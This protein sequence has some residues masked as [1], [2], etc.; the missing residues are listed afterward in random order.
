MTPGRAR[1]YILDGQRTVPVKD[2]LEWGEWFETA[3]RIIK[4]DMIQGVH[5]STVFLGLDHGCGWF[6]PQPGCK[7]L[8]FET[9]VFG[10][11]MD[12]YQQ[13]YSTWKGAE[14]GHDKVVQL[15]RDKIAEEK[16]K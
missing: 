1:Y 5:V 14:Y 7:P 3:D 4:S 12:M 13:R 11:E 6:D 10:G 16:K 9:M 2:V 15:V 8:L